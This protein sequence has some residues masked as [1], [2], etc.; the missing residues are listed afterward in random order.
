MVDSALI[1]VHCP[2]VPQDAA[3]MREYRSRNRTAAE[4][5]LAAGRARR[6]AF[7]RF[8]ASH[9]DEFARIFA[10]ERAKEGL[11]PVGVLKKGP[12]PKSEAA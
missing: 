10:E 3:Y 8:A 6:N 2:V 4:L 9:P 1:R 5:N 11:P 7:R 12:K